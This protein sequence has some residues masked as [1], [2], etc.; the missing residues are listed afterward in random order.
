M[1]KLERQVSHL[2]ARITKL[3]SRL[4]KVK[5]LESRLDDLEFPRPR[6]VHSWDQKRKV[7]VG[8][9]KRRPFLERRSEK[10]PGGYPREERDDGQADI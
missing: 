8:R 10:G 7:L 5:R 3:E 2:E 9:G 6:G 4:I 1:R